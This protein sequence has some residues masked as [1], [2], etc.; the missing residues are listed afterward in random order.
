MQECYE[1]AK[2]LKNKKLELV[3]LMYIN[4]ITTKDVEN[5]SE[6]PIKIMKDSLQVKF[7][8]LILYLKNT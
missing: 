7:L 8:F 1:I 3:C 5:K 2:K 6:D 4:K